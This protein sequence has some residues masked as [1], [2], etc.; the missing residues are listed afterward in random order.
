MTA[1]LPRSLSPHLCML[2]LGLMVAACAGP[3]PPAAA[4]MPQV[5]G[6]RIQFPADSPQLTF[7]RTEPANGADEHTLVLPGRLEWDASR[8]SHVV[9]ALN[10]QVLRIQ[11]R[12][13]QSVRKGDA[14]AVI[15]SP[16]FGAAQAERARAVAELSQAQQELQ[17][18]SEL[19][20]AGV[21]ATRELE[22]A[23]KD[24][25][26]ASAEHARLAARAKLYGDA[27]DVDQAF[28]LRAPIDGI[29][30]ERRV[31]PG[32]WVNEDSDALFTLSDPGSLWLFIDVPEHLLGTI[33]PGQ[34]VQAQTSAG[35]QVSAQIE[36]VADHVDAVT[37]TVTARASV[38]N[39]Q[40]SLKAGSFLRIQIEV[41]AVAGVDVPAGAILLIDDQQ[42][43]FVADAAGSYWRQPV[44]AS[45]IDRGRMRITQG[46]QAGTQVVV[47]GALLLQ[48]A[49]V[50]HASG[51]QS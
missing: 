49:M 35:M 31:N 30:V 51:P 26:A 23:Q 27:G 10:G 24:A 46:L 22:Q 11:A 42:W 29:V 36:Y 48:Q 15:A 21:V 32:Q 7:I 50:E 37:R 9:A 13:G 44:A 25:A 3:K 8:T 6:D 17:R 12:P 39:P 18:M 5:Q 34:Q 33:Q 1:L 2:A 16:D 43:V 45:A 40:R 20:A 41:P 4:P 28:V 14:L 47:Q 19:H 38:A